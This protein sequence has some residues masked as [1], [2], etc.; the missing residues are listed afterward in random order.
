[1]YKRQLFATAGK[2]GIQ[3]QTICEERLACDIMLIDDTF[4]QAKEALAGAVSAARPLYVI[5]R[6]NS[7]GREVPTRGINGGRAVSLAQSGDILIT[8]R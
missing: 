5:V 2:A 1:M 8:V 4:A 7:Y 3:Q 6:D